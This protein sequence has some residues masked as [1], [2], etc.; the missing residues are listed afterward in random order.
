MKISVFH[1]HI[2]QVAKETGRSL[3]ECLQYYA[4]RGL[5]ALEIHSLS[6]NEIGWETLKG[7]LE[8]TGFQLSSIFRIFDFAKDPDIAPVRE[9]L[10]QAQFFDV[11]NVM[12]VPGWYQKEDRR[13]EEKAQIVAVFRQACA[14]GKEYGV[15]ITIEDF[16][17]SNTIVSTMDSM[18]W[19]LEQV[20]DLKV[21]LD[22]GNFMYSD[23]DLLEAFERMKDRI[24]HVHMKDQKNACPPGYDRNPDRSSSGVAIYPSPLGEGILPLREIL[25]RLDGIGYEGYLPIEIFHVQNMQEDITKSIRWIRETLNSIQKG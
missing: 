19:L 12:F 22:T 16:G 9:V 15:E 2:D 8:R 7:I 13:E 14:L 21:T 17:S 24:V 1:A 5:E 4:D 3:E 10:E 23:G 11:K 6:I 20:E 18:L 25:E